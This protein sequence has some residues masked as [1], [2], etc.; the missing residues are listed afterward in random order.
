MT[1]RRGAGRVRSVV[2]AGLIAAAGLT[3]APAAQAGPAEELDGAW[4]AWSAA[5]SLLWREFNVGSAPGIDSATAARRRADTRLFAALEAWSSAG[6]PSPLDREAAVEAALLAHR[7]GPDA[8]A[9]AA[10]RRLLEL[11]PARDANRGPLLLVLGSIAEGAKQADEALRSWQA[12]AD[13]DS[14]PARDVALLR[15]AKARAARGD[16]SGAAEAMRR[17]LTLGSPTPRADEARGFLATWLVER[18]QHAEALGFLDPLISGS[19][20]GEDGARLYRLRARALTG[21][22]RNDEARVAWG[23]LIR[24]FP[25]TSAARTGWTEFNAWLEARGGSPTPEERMNGGNA[26]LRSGE[27]ARGLELLHSVRDGAEVLPLVRVDA[28]E[29]ESSWLFSRRRYGDARLAWRQ[30]GRLAEGVSARRVM[31]ARLGEARSLRNAGLTDEMAATFTRLAADTTDR[32]I[33]ARGLWELAKE[34]RSLGRFAACESTLDVY[35]DRFPYGEEIGIAIQARGVLRYLAGRY[36]PA[37]EDFQLLARRSDRLADRE[38]AAFWRGRC[39]EAAGDRAGAIE[40]YRSGLAPEMPDNYYGHRLRARLVELDA[41]DAISLWRPAPRFDP[42][43]NTWSPGGLDDIEAR[44]RAQFLK[45]L[46]LARAGFY[47]EAQQDLNRAAE[48]SP[49]DPTFVDVNA[50]LG[51]RLGLYSFGMQ[52]ARRALGRVESRA[53]E[54]RLWRY[55]YALGWFDLVREAARDNDLDPMLVTGLIRQESLF[56]ERAVSRA[57]AR[58]LMQLMLP[59]ARAMARQLGD[60]PPSESTLLRPE[61]SVRYGCRYFRQKI[62]EFD[63]RIEMAL[64]AY[65]AGEAKAREW[66]GLLPSWD[67]DLYMEMIDYMETKDYVRRVRYNQA[68]YHLFYDPVQ[69]GGA[70]G[71]AR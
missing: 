20:K 18:G 6:G 33:A 46:S 70:D 42:S 62:D 59:T 37:R 51:V 25:G 31:E 12:A 8:T 58:G 7:E 49:D 65:N 27:E 40:E 64:A 30:M 50:A 16:S 66:A 23:G 28:A 14:F 13:L 45:G 68:T 69:A 57:G 1:G 41:L 4:R 5:D 44:S 71:L 17:I 56:D 35:I 19:V 60:D 43:R 9:A 24:N 15:L 36:D 52:S 48:M 11:L 39:R 61:I 47:P 29:K 34:Y 2:I 3:L 32:A 26:L 63:G 55:V 53:D 21:L 67:P 38:A 10:I 22:G 54:A